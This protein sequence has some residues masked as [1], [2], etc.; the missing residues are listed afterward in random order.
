MIRRLVRILRSPDELGGN[1]IGEEQLSFLSEMLDE[2][3]DTG[4]DE[5]TLEDPKEGETDKPVEGKEVEEPDPDGSN[6]E[7]DI[8]GELEKESSPEDIIK[9][10]REQLLNLTE[11]VQVDPKVQSVKEDVSQQVIEQDQKVVD[12]AQQTLANFLTEDE[13]DRIIDEP[14][15]LNLAFQ[16]AQAAN[17]V[18]IGQL[19]QQEVQRQIM[20]SKAITDFYTA[21]NDLLPY[22]KFVQFVMSDVESK[23]KDKTYG[24]IFEETASECRKRLGLANPNQQVR[25][26]NNGQQKPAFAGSK[27]GNSRPVGK[28]EWFDASAEEMMNTN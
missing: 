11:L 2:P 14:Q 15:L 1:G 21:N 25:Q 10:L 28:E 27:R 20:V 26:T 3:T 17:S 8:A 19:V 16:R 13:L 4:N 12:K 5:Q 6:E 23:N 18:Q 22:S 9:S 7:G 24:Q